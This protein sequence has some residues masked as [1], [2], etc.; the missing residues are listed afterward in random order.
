MLGKRIIP[1]SDYKI[2]LILKDRLGQKKYPPIDVIEVISNCDDYDEDKYTLMYM[3]KYGID[4]VRG[5]SY[6]TVKL[7]ETT[8]N[9]LEQSIRSA[10]NRCF[11]CGGDHFA[12]DCSVEEESS[13]FSFECCP[14]CEGDHHPKDC[15]DRNNDCLR[16]GRFNWDHFEGRTCSWK[17]DIAGNKI[18]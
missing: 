5:G 1:N 14:R 8:V 12:K 2:I 6:V 13:D 7:P 3:C 15:P 16:C 17:I 18:Y 4:N 10:N 9:H 11:Y